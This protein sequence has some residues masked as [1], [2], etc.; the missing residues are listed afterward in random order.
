M[1]EDL[2]KQAIDVIPEGKA[3]QTEQQD[4]PGLLG[5]FPRPFS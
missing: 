3:H 5:D 2:L 1:R 4:D